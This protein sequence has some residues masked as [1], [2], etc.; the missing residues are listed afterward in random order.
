MN[1]K[2]NLKYLSLFEA[3]GHRYEFAAKTGQECISIDPPRD[4][5]IYFHR[6]RRGITL[7][8]GISLAN[9]ASIVSCA[10]YKTQCG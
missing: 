7:A 10:K 2:I 6:D 8:K 9:L 4:M 5:T 3:S 1:R